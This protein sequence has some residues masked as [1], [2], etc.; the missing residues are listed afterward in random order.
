M[1]WMSRQLFAGAL[2]LCSSLAFAQGNLVS[3]GSSYDDHCSVMLLRERKSAL[4]V[5]AS[6]WGLQSQWKMTR[7]FLSLNK[8]LEPNGLVILYSLSQEALKGLVESMQSVSADF[9]IKRLRP[10]PGR[11]GESLRFLVV[12]TKWPH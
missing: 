10:I 12:I 1:G 7:F 8:T 9:Y 2:I 11:Q 5:D 3:S 6:R 4:E